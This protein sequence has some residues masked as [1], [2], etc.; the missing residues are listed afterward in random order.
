[1]KKKILLYIIVF[2][3]LF[4]SPNKVYAIN[5]DDCTITCDWGSPEISETRVLEDTILKQYEDNSNQTEAVFTLRDI[6]DKLRVNYNKIGDYYNLSIKATKCYCPIAPSAY[7]GSDVKVEKLAQTT[8]VSETEAYDKIE[9]LI[10]NQFSNFNSSSQIENGIPEIYCSNSRVSIDKDST[11][12]IVK[13]L[14]AVPTPSC[15]YYYKSIVYPMIVEETTSPP[16]YKKADKYVVLIFG[17]ISFKYSMSSSS[18]IKEFEVFNT[19]ESYGYYRYD[20][21][22]DY[23]KMYKLTSSERTKFMNR[24]KV[25]LPT[26]ATDICHEEKDDNCYLYDDDYDSC[27]TH[28][29]CNNANTIVNNK[30]RVD[31]KIDNY[32]EDTSIVAAKKG[33]KLKYKVVV[34]NQGGDISHS[35][36]ITSVI[37]DEL[38]YVTGSASGG[39]VYSKTTKTIT[40]L[41]SELYPNTRKE[42]T[43]NVTVNNDIADINTIQMRSSIVSD[44][45]TEIQSTPVTVTVEE[46]NSSNVIPIFD[47]PKTGAL[48]SIIMLLS[49]LV[50]VG[51]LTIK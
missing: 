13:P 31:L 38:T 1:M 26:V 41:V 3:A 33:D 14:A 18:Y 23:S 37:P 16:G 17:V 30:S 32:I 22:Y 15:R 43:Y 8:I 12:N 9:E 2:I 42:L 11:N 39:G 20:Q 21:F 44:E 51:F 6:N 29:V 25:N 24:Y 47:S 35:N 4:F 50:I 27:P 48:L 49:S 7:N 5:Q 34:T 46:K 36:V 40:W 10:L 28:T 45:I 19:D